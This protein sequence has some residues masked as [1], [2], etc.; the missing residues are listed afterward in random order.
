[1][2]KNES[3]LSALA[4][5]STYTRFFLIACYASLFGSLLSACSTSP[6][7]SNAQHSQPRTMQEQVQLT[8]RISIQYQQREQTETISTSFEWQ[9]APQELTIT[10]SSPL[11]QTIATVQ[12]N[13]QGAVLTQAKQEPRSAPDIEQLLAENL[14][15]T[16]PVT[17]L[18]GWLQGFDIQANGKFAAVP[19]QDYFQVQS[20]GWQL[21]FISWQEDAGTIRPKRID[22]QRYTEELGEVKIKIIIEPS[23]Q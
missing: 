5:Y 12:Q 11:G 17:G 1:M 18:K 8:G 14:G 10:L 20:Q 9:Q 15:W 4:T 22:L 6:K 7:F 13:A 23:A 19:V 21:Q 2:L 3:P 16:I